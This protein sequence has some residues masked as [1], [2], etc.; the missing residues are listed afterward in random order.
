MVTL[1]ESYKNSDDGYICIGST[2]KRGGWVSAG[3]LLAT[4]V[5]LIALAGLLLLGRSGRRL[6]VMTLIAVAW[7]IAATYVVIQVNDRWVEAF[8]LTSLI[9][10][11][12]PIAEEITKAFVLPFLSLSRRAVWFVDGA[13]LGA[14]A[15]TGFAIRENWLYLERVGSDETLSLAIARVT[16]TN[17]MHAGCTAIVGAAIVL[18]YS[19][20]WRARIALPLGALAIAITLHSIF[21]RLTVNEDASTLLVT[22]VGIGVFAI[23]VGIVFLGFPISA[24][25]VRQD[26]ANQGATTSEQVALSGGSV[27]DVLDAF[28]SRYGPDAA[29][30]AEQLV[31]A[32][33]ALAIAQHSGRSSAA[34]ISSLQNTTDSI[35][36]N[37]GMFQM[38][39][40]RSHLPVD[41]SALGLWTL[42]DDSTLVTHDPKKPTPSGMWAR[43][44][45]SMETPATQSDTTAQP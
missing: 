10:L 32:Q 4:V 7:G 9:V 45:E 3:I 36:R 40:L 22:V 11:G 14:A 26:L 28:E 43:L 23:A 2:W 15:G 16:S 6:W 17:L 12:A 42:I 27:A 34:E 35:R 20:G 25:W 21:N 39:W 41:A 29:R 8:G 1:L 44:D 5:P 24:R 38:M 37:I 33:R 19:R 18:S 30:L 31:Q 13:V